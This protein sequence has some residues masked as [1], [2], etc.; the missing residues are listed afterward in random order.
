ME[1]LTINRVGEKAT[2]FSFVT[3]I[4][5]T[6]ELFDINS[7]Y[8]S[9]AF[10]NPECSRC[11]AMIDSLISNNTLNNTLK[12]DKFKIII[13][14]PIDNQFNNNQITMPNKWIK[15]YDYSGAIVA[16]KLYEIRSFP[17]VYILDKEKK[18]IAKEISNYSIIKKKLSYFQNY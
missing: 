7:D 15:G 2:N 8:I 16:K 13:I 9:L 11:H 6:I 1:K 17:S 14:N 10:I 3:D 12:K 18:I 5:D 4:N